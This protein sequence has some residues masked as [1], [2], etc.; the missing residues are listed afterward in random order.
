MHVLSAFLSSVHIPVDPRVCAEAGERNSACHAVLHTSVITPG[1]RVVAS[2]IWQ[3]RSC[4]LLHQV[5]GHKGNIDVAVAA[6]F[7][8]I[9]SQ[10]SQHLHHA[11]TMQINHRSM[12]TEDTFDLGSSL[13]RWSPLIG[14]FY[15]GACSKVDWLQYQA[16]SGRS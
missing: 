3:C 6:T 2:W 13:L 16:P 11:I 7:C 10:L 4:W 8:T 9:P 15:E 5:D 1:R 14:D 12:R